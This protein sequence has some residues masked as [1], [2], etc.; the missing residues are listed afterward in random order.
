MKKLF[1]ILLFFCPLFFQAQL[2]TDLSLPY[3][4][5]E[6]SVKTNNPPVIILLHGYG[7]NEADL[8]GLQSQFPTTFLVISAR[9]PIVMTEN[10]F[11]WFRMETV[12]GVMQGNKED[13]K[14]SA[15]KIKAF[16]KQVTSKYK[17]TAGNTVLCGFSQG[18][19]MSYEVGLTSPD[20]LKGIAPLSG[21]IFE[22]L[23]PQVKVSASLKVLKVFIGHGDAD[24]RV[25]YSFA[26]EAESYLKTLGLSP[27]LHTYTG[28]AHSINQAELKDLVLWLEGK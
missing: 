9:A 26:T 6:P 11:Q 21:K 22:S 27:V 19:M 3:L 7:S 15:D 4:V 20:L 2:Q 5:R 12:N 23:K 13:L 10:S 16:I 14:S 18:A 25:A 8:F 17:T 24:N 28:M 1:A